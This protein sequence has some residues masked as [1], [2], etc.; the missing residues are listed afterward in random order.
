[1]M[2]ATLADLLPWCS[3][4]YIQQQAGIFFDS[5]RVKNGALLG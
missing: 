2:G 4:K 3:M 5:R 1:M